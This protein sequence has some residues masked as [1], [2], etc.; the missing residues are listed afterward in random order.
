MNTSNK[1]KRILLRNGCSCTAI[2]GQPANWNKPGAN[3]NA[4]WRVEFRF[5]DPAYKDDPKLSAGKQFSIKRGINQYHTLAEKREIMQALIE[6]VELQIIEKGYNPITEMYM[7]PEEA[8]KEDDYIISPNST[9]IDALDAAY[10]RMNKAESTL[11]DIR[12]VK[13]GFVTSAKQVR[14]HDLPIKDVKRRHIIKVL[15]NCRLTN[16]NFT[17]KRFNKYRSYLQ[18]LFGVLEEVEA[19][20]YNPIDKLPIKPVIK[21]QRELLTPEE[22]KLINDHLQKNYYRFWLFTQIFYHSGARETELMKVKRKDVD[23]ENQRYKVTILKGGL[24]TEEWK[25]IK[26]VAVQFWWIAILDSK[27]NDYIFSEGLLPGPRKIRVEQI[28]RRWREHVKIKL[29]IDKDFYSLKHLNSDE[30]DKLHGIEVAAAH[31]SHTSTKTTSGHY[32]VTHK[33]R[34]NEVLK[35]VNNSF[36]PRE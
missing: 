16:K 33:E 25:V 10:L 27:P 2:K 14:L 5:Y 22:R 13:K 6:E 17:D 19:I 11:S 36:V 7:L 24:Y 21:Q 26:N 1:S 15:D 34:L 18:M 30:T 9:L 29:G 12:S 32:A 20:D 8:K 28:T 31:N 35:K 3:V 4:V 23:L